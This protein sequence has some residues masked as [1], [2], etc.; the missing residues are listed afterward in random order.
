MIRTVVAFTASVLI[1]ATGA[2]MHARAQA[3]PQQR[4]IFR[5]AS[6]LVT[7]DV[8]VT[9]DGR[10]VGALGP[11]DFVLTDNGVA[12]TIESVDMT[13]VPADI[14]III[15]VNHMLFDTLSDMVPD[16]ERVVKHIRP[17]DRVRLMTIDTYVRD[18]VPLRDVAGFPAFERLDVNEWASAQDALAAALMRDA[19]ER[20]HL[21]VAITNGVDTSSTIDLPTLEQIA[22]RASA[23]LHIVTAD[24]FLFV[25]EEGNRIF[26]TRFE[27]LKRASVGFQSRFWRFHH[28]RPFEAHDTMAVGTGGSWTMP[29]I[30]SDQNAGVIFR[31]FYERSQRS[32]RIRYVPTGVAREGWHDVSISVPKY[33]SYT[34][35]V[36]PGYS[37]AR[38]RPT[39]VSPPT[40]GTIADVVDRYGAGDVAGAMQIVRSAPESSR[41]LREYMDGLHAWPDNPQREAAFVLD[42]TVAGLSSPDRETTSTVRDLIARQQQ[43]VR[44]PLGPGAFERFWLWSAAALGL[45]FNAHDLTTRIVDSARERFP[46]EP[47]L[48]LIH[49]V[50]LDRR[51][52][53][54]LVNSSQVRSERTTILPMVGSTAGSTITRIVGPTGATVPAG[55]VTDVLAAYD[56][57]IAADE[58]A[59]EARV[60]KA[61]VLHRLDR[62]DEALELL[63]VPG[64]A[65]D[66]AIEYTRHLFRGTVFETIGR[67]EDARDAFTMAH[68]LMP[69]AQSARVALMRHAAMA[70][71][72]AEAATLSEAVQ[73][74]TA[75]DPW[76]SYW[77]ADFRLVGAALARMRASER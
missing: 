50:L 66:V 10:P 40:A 75:N 56:T 37:V 15:D 49:A 6:D 62:N 46:G 74:T 52:P 47:R 59:A 69:D 17:G 39:E 27:R 45:G 54:G 19:G 7:M 68:Q 71:D 58:T 2:V 11:A 76:W 53:G 13:E 60:R 28:E 67:N 4:P 12:Q 22:R 1:L 77:Q 9:V 30:F 14:T 21:I 24:L 36:R 44:D 34:L 31:R 33:P 8:V 42:L 57:A 5:T 55:H 26:T 70:G 16:I 41:L 35:T 63:D 32:Y 3:A 43:L 18:L 72:M 38:E 51:Y 73:T 20:R 61:W 29:G 65:A 64:N 23:T 25:D 48:D